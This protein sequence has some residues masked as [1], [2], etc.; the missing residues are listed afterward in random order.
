MTRR[1]PQR[2]WSASAARTRG[3]GEGVLLRA[4]GPAGQLGP[5]LAS[6]GR[7]EWNLGKILPV[8]PPGFQLQG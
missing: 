7:W 5:G 8:P 4:S 3:T 2:A 6:E 1:R